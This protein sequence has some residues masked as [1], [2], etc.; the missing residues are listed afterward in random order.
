MFGRLITETF[1]FRPLPVCAAEVGCGVG[2]PSARARASRLRGV[3]VGGRVGLEGHFH[4]RSN[5][6]GCRR[7][8]EAEGKPKSLI[9]ID[10]HEL[11]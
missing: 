2:V 4:F 11:N 5:N 6:R 7:T 1:S 8:E 3:A 9:V 10:T